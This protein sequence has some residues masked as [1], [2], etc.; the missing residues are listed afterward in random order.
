MTKPPETQPPFRVSITGI[1]GA[2]K[3][4][5]TKLTL[6]LLAQ[7]FN[8]VVKLGRPAYE[9]NQDGER[10]IFRRTTEGMDKIHQLSDKVHNK[11]LITGVNALNVMV[12]TRV[13]ERNVL[14]KEP[15][16]DILVSS[17]DPRVDPA[18]YFT[19]YAPDVFRRNIGIEKRVRTMQQL[20]GVTRNLIVLLKVDPNVAVERIEARIQ[21]E[22][23]E[24]LA[25]GQATADV[26]REK[27]RHIHENIADLT[28]LS[29]G[30]DVAIDALQDV[31][32]TTVVE[33]NTT[34]LERHQVVDFARL[35]ISGAMNHS[36]TQYE[37]V[38]YP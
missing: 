20:T 31:Q 24:R 36:I 11:N 14:A 5:V 3:D 25:S 8:S 23:E 15:T 4:T 7:D 22:R 29:E 12:Q 16:P 33:I 28:M 27:W 9:F 35:A 2:G 13:L 1:D 21:A 34:E 10:Q 37:K 26:M 19:Y 30:Y 18:V 17:R 38:S 32:P 6:G